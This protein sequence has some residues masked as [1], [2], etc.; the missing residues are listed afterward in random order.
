[1][2]RGTV[3]R[4]LTRSRSCGGLS[5]LTSASRYCGRDVLPFNLPPII[6]RGTTG[7]FQYQLE[8]IGDEPAADLAA[9]MGA[10]ISAVDRAV[11]RVQHVQCLDAPGLSHVDRKPGAD[12]RRRR[13]RHLPA[14]GGTL[15]GYFINQ[16]NICGRVWQVILQTRARDR[17][18]VDDIYRINVRNN[19]N[20]MAPLRSILTAKPIVG[21]QQITRYNNLRRVT[22][23]GNPASGHSSDEALAAMECVSQQVLPSGFSYE[24]TST[25]L[26][27]QEAAGQ[28]FY[29]LAIAV[30]FAYLLL[31]GL[32]ESWA[33]PLAVLS[34]TVGSLG[35]MLT[36]RLSG[37]A[38]DLFAQIGIR[39]RF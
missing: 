8:A 30:V 24:W 35:A 25:A 34:V 11:R 39:M 10:L 21:P 1:V 12:P 38:N 17:T 5:S 37:L 28:T 6:G 36:P 2:P 4:A 18:Q 32:Y 29:I 26:Q 19:K 16:F 33:I 15:G 13:E 22:F 27:Q 7:G 3:G 9:T 31:V 23:K 20:E 14:L